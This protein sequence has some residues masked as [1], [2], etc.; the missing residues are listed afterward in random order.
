[1]DNE[2]IRNLIQEKIPDRKVRCVYRICEAEDGR[3]V[4]G[5]N[6]NNNKIFSIAIINIITGDI[7][8]R[9]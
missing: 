6:G 2:D 1:M 5:V 9:Y 4:F 8:I 7:E 3:L